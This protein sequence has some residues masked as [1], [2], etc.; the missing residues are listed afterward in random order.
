MVR[1]TAPTQL[2]P[3][4]LT[5]QAGNSGGNLNKGILDRFNDDV[6]NDDML[7]TV[8]REFYVSQKPEPEPKVRLVMPETTTLTSLPTVVVELVDYVGAGIDFDASTV[9]V[10]NLQGVLVP[11]RPLGHD[12]VSNTLTWTTEAVFRPGGRDDGEYT[13]TATFIDFTGKSFTRQF[14]FVLD[15]QVPEV[16][17]VHVAIDSR[18]ELSADT[19]T[20]LTENF[21]QIIVTFD[22][23]GREPSA[24]SNQQEGT[25][26]S[27]NLLTDIDF[28]DTVVELTGP[29]GDNSDQWSLSIVPRN[30]P[31]VLLS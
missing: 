20:T 12:E 23:G 25:I 24:V 9:T 22:S 11:Q 3:S 10:R 8:L 30:L 5:W 2:K 13:I 29:A 4:S 27:E 15:T 21:S 1:M 18:P 16:E 6:L 17:S 19:I 26:P 14:S 28:A 7:P 31:S